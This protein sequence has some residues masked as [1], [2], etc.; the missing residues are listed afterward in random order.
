MYIFLKILRLVVN[1]L[2]AIAYRYIG[3]MWV[4]II[5]LFR[6][7]DNKGHAEMTG[8]FM[9]LWKSSINIFGIRTTKLV[10]FLLNSFL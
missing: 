1:V 9:R 7:Y 10:S 4:Y 8:C 5:Q 2:S 6:V 3:S